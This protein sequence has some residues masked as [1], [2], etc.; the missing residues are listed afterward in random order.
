MVCA[1][2][3]IVVDLYTIQTTKVIDCLNLKQQVSTSSTRVHA[4]K[5]VVAEEGTVLPL[6]E[7]EQV[8]AAT[9]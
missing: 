1:N 6:L 7:E 9:P 4:K 3:V 5:A 2:V 8:W